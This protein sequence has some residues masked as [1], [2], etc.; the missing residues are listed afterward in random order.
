MLRVTNKNDFDLADRYDGQ[1][2]FF[3]SGKTVMCE[4]AAARHIFGVGDENKKPY[5]TRQG[6]MKT[7]EDVEKATA[8]LNNFSFEYVEQ[9]YDVEFARIEHGTS[10]HAIAGAEG[11]TGADE[12]AKPSATAPQ[13]RNILSKVKRIEQATA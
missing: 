8:I 10:P 6:W 7:S 13:G 9:T 4:D 11:E 3:P 1:A 2:Y 5:M 12:S